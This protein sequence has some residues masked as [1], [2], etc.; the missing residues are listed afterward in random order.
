MGLL[1]LFG[2]ESKTTTNTTNQF[3]DKSVN[4]GDGSVALGENA[5]LQTTTQIYAEQLS[6]DVAL[7]AIGGMERTAAAGF[8]ANSDVAGRALATN[9]DVARRALEANRD[10]NLE[11]L[12]TTKDLARSAINSVQS[13]GETASRERVDVLETTNY[14]LQS[15]QGVTDKLA[16]LA[17]GA[18]ERS[19][20]PDSQVSKQL[21]WALAAIA[22]ILGLTFIFRSNRASK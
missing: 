20:T 13:I 9:Q 8:A 21:I 16:Q 19:Q 12:T 18:L 15:Q 2:K 14:A 10:V 5:N 7:G 4:A 6:D 3:T 17:A 11:S 22:A 1:N